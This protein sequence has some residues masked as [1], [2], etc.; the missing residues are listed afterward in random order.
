MSLV[1]NID[2]ILARNSQL[3]SET[4]GQNVIVFSVT[5]GAYFDL[6][7][8]GSEIWNMLTVPRSVCEILEELSQRYDSSEDTITRDVIDF[9]R[10]LI[11]LDL[12]Q[13]LNSG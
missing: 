3:F 5:A 7:R 13:S 8:V 1:V 6:N 12:I 10:R 2:T 9:L 11:E 4:V